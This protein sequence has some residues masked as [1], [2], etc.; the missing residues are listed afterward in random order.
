MCYS[1]KALVI[2]LKE[3]KLMYATAWSLLPPVV[4]IVLALITKE[5]YSSLFIGIL[6][7]A[8][9]ATSFNPLAAL[10]TTFNDGFFTALCDTWNMGIML[11]L[12]I[13]GIFVALIN[14]SGGSHAYGEWAKK[15]IKTKK[16]ALAS[17]FVLSL[18]LGIDDY[19]HCLTVGSVMLPVNDSH[20]ISR[21]RFA[22][23]ID[24]TA[25]PLCMIFPISSWAAAVAGMVEGY[26][27]IELFV[28]AIPYN[29]YSLLSLLMILWL[30]CTGLEYGP[31]RKHEENAL[32]GDLFTTPDRPY[33]DGETD[34]EANPRAGI[35]D[36]VIPIIVLF[37]SCVIF[38]LYTG[39]F[40]SGTPF[41]DAFAGCDASYA[42]A[43][44]SIVALLI[45]VIYY[46]IRRVITFKASMECIPTG[47]KAMVPAI[48][49]LSLAL[50]LKN[51]TSLMGSTEFV[52]NLVQSNI[53][54]FGM[55]LPLILFVIACFI[56]FSTGTSWGTFGI[57]IPITVGLGGV[58]SETML[59]ICI[60]ACLAGAVCGDH[61]SP[62]SDTTIMASAGARC[63]HINHVST[64]LPYA[65]TVAGV[66]AVSY[67]LAGF[68]QN[69][70]VLPIAIVL[71]VGTLIVIG[72]ITKSKDYTKQESA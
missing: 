46:L 43:L 45:T 33:A 54:S 28:R 6:V 51:M 10:E 66:S 55:F 56:S 19:F 69:I 17:T 8:L 64:Q 61:C 53:D 67:L 65:L 13:L 40:F 37:I 59:I 16:G 44:G 71:M 41:I 39:G 25:A 34:N 57:L 49:I 36:L 12:V 58:L 20:N 1:R 5:V 15:R 7:G 23:Q 3:G 4:A 21:A 14:K 2:N 70:I 63:N 27:G 68:I 32:K 30:I 35:I 47:F 9:L 24:A 22:Y 18:I 50:T 60:S 31:M 48:L 29:F 26:N 38:M 72:K 62:I 52:T 11:F 42:L